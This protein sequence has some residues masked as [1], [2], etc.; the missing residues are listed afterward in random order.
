MLHS[1][2]LPLRYAVFAAVATAI[3]V[4]TQHLTLVAYGGAFALTA[5]MAL[6]TGTGL[7]TKYIL[8]KQYIFFDLDNSLRGHTVKFTLYTAMGLATT[9]I[10]WGTEIL[11]HLLLPGAG[12]KYLG[13]VV[14]LAIGYV[15]KYRLDRRYVFGVSPA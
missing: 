9:A 15:T 4:G 14:G 11:F 6:G 12:M 2:A 10:F 13:A 1:A 5:A 3:N 8:D 7:V